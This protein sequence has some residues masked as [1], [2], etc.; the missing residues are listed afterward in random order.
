MQEIKQNSQLGTNCS[1]KILFIYRY[2][3]L[4]IIQCNNTHEVIILT[5]T[6]LCFVVIKR[7][8]VYLI[9]KPY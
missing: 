7:L 4:S 8:N 5:G 2:K 9:N 6:F 3:P 1:Q